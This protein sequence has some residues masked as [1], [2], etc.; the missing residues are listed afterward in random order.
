M[1]VLLR[2]ELVLP[3]SAPC[4][5]P[6]QPVETEQ[7]LGLCCKGSSLSVHVGKKISYI[8]DR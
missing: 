8:I 3:G 5:A 2:L 7:P 4:P 1:P 6:S